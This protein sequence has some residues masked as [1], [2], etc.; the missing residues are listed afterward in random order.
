MMVKQQKGFT[1]IELMIVVAIIGI[2]AAIALPSYQQSVIKSRR[3]AAQT[4]LMDMAT[5]EERYYTAN[6][7]YTATLTLLGYTGT[8]LPAPSS[9][10]NLYT[11]SIVA[12]TTACPIGSCYELT[13]VPVTGTTQAND[14]LCATFKINSSGTRQKTGTDTIKSCWGS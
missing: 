6:N 10:N 11:V 8:T 1:L 12:A 7:S 5:R 14:A 9:N 4:A 13:A 3:V 2:L